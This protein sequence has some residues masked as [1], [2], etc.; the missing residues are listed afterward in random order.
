VAG[1]RDI[2]DDQL[3]A[4]ADELP[5]LSN[6]GRYFFNSSRFIFEVSKPR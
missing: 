4:W 2:D 5:Q 3:T 6:E 1:R